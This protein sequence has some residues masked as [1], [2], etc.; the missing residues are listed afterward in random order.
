MSNTHVKSWARP[1]N[2]SIGGRGIRDTCVAELVWQPAW[3]NRASSSVRGPFSRPW[4]RSDRGRHL[5]LFWPL[6]THT[7]TLMCVHCTPPHRIVY[8]WNSCSVWSFGTDFSQNISV[9]LPMWATAL[10]SNSHLTAEKC[11]PLWSPG[12]GIWVLPPFHSLRIG[13]LWTLVYILLCWLAGWVVVTWS[14]VA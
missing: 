2:P 9:E 13:L 14:L 11:L 3:Q 10:D 7:H 8:T 12:R 6:C 4:G 1:V 5:M